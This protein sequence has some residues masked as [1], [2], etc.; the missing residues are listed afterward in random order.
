M[1]RRV[2]VSH[3][4]L[5]RPK[6]VMLSSDMTMDTVLEACI[7]AVCDGGGKSLTLVLDVPKHPEVIEE[8]Q[9]LRQRELELQTLIQDI[10]LEI[11]HVD[12]VVQMWKEPPVH[13]DNDALAQESFNSEMT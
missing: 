12:E 3:S 1:S 9:K 10:Q 6:T 11:N 5:T 2:F 13:S 8:L 4:A 7:A